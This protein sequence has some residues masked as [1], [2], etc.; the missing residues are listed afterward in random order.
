MTAAP[1]AGPL[2]VLMFDTLGATND[3]SNELIEAL[4]ATGEVALAVLTLEGSRLP[5]D[6]PATV[7]RLLPDFGAPEPR[8]VKLKKLLRAY[9][10]F[11]R[12]AAAQPRGGIVHVQFFKFAWIEAPLLL[13]M[14]ALFGARLVFTAHNTLPHVK[15]RWH[16]AFY[17]GWYGQVDLLHVL[18]RNVEREI[19]GPLGA[20]PRR[21]VTIEHGS[22]RTLLRRFGGRRTQAQARAALGLP[23]EGFV[24]LQYGL[25]REY[26]GLGTLMRAFALLPADLHVRLLL[27]GGGYADELEGWKDI[28]RRAGCLDRVHWIERYVSDEELVGCLTAADLAVFPYRNISQ[29][30]ALV[31]ALT[32]GVASIANDL[33]GFREALPAIDDAFFARDDAAAL[34]AHIE[35]LV[36]DPQ[37]LARLRA[38][39][40]AH[41]QRHLGWDGI[42]QRMLA[43]YRAAVADRGSGRR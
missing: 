8:L 27:A 30:G 32:F 4:A 9:A 36:R 35:A 11:W 28:A 6:T 38:A 7:L 10:A 33:P 34:A 37:R 41:A 31:L 15:K 25:F 2:P 16:A 42:A 18:S 20:A 43:A 17:R 26:K 21:V 1:G 29:S 39:L 19:V 23:A 5:A 13:A 40:A 3:Y 12:A 14:R 24:L 22:Y